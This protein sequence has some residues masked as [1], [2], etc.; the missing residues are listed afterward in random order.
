[1]T[2]TKCNKTAE[3]EDEK[4]CPCKGTGE[5]NKIRCLVPHEDLDRL[6][7]REIPVDEFSF[8]PGNVWSLGSTLAEGPFSLAAQIRTADEWRSV[9]NKYMRAPMKNWKDWKPIP[10]GFQ[11]LK[12]PQ[13]IVKHGWQDYKGDYSMFALGSDNRVMRALENKFGAGGYSC[14]KYV[15]DAIKSFKGVPMVNPTRKGIAVKCCCGTKKK[16]RLA[17]DLPRGRNPLIERMLREEKRAR[18]Y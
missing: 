11:A 13:F 5:L 10:A 4:K 2:C 8:K 18:G 15:N 6:V 3:G 12:T 7:W 9:Y 17:D 14:V 1:M 16:R